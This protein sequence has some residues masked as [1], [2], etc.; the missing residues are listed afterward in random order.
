MK[1]K[2]DFKTILILMMI[3]V[4]FIIGGM[5][6]GIDYE[7]RKRQERDKVNREYFDNFNENFQ[8][9]I[10]DIKVP[11][12]KLKGGLKQCLIKVKLDYSTTKHYDPRDS[13]KH[14]YCV[15]DYPF[16]EIIEE[17]GGGFISIGDSLTF[18]GIKDTCYIKVNSWA[19]LKPNII[20]NNIQLLKPLYTIPKYTPKQLKK[21]IITYPKPL[22]LP[23]DYYM[24]LF[25]RFNK[26]VSLESYK[27]YQKKYFEKREGLYYIFLSNRRY[28]SYQE[29][30]QAKQE[31]GFADVM[32]SKFDKHNKLIKVFK[33]EKKKD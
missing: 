29:A 8:G 9:V 32:I 2:S 25:A 4:A 30:I 14:F 16:A 17:Y 21:Q 22:E 7:P 31:G 26:K 5:L 12:E 10:V 18:D 19:E 23:N 11:K 24:L 6:A 33:K 13:L 1:Q 20:D 3:V 28:G 15:I 27:I